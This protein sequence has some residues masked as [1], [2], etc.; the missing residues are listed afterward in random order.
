MN[1]NAEEQ[2][3]NNSFAAK[4]NKSLFNS[5]NVVGENN[6]KATEQ[7]KYQKKVYKMEQHH[8]Q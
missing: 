3:S 6:I 2:K 4:P 7:D 8:K 1:F 5:I